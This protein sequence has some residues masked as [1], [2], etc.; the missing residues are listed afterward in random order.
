PLVRWCGRGMAGT[1]PLPPIP[2]DR[3]ARTRQSVSTFSCISTPLTHLLGYHLGDRAAFIDAKFVRVAALGRAQVCA[4]P[5]PGPQEMI[6]MIRRLVGPAVI[7][8]I[9]LSGCGRSTSLVS[10]LPDGAAS[11]AVTTAYDA[12]TRNL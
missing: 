7:A 3:H 9:M 10:V 1:S 4:C 12:T 5:P 11:D 8:I 2:I 6:T